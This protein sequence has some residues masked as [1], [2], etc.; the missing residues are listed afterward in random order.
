MVEDTATEATFTCERGII[1][2]N[3]MFHMPTTVTI[4][5]NGKDEIIDF[6]TKTIGYNF[7]TEHFNNLLRD[8]KKESD[9]MTF[10][11]SKN[12]IKTLDTVRG[13]IGLEY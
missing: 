13:I 2:I 4:A 11:F 5:E 9:I 8:H 6:K 1:K 12:L 3:T 10:E 7:E